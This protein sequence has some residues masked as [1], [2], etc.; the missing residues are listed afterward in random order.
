MFI[1]S[2]GDG[3][4]AVIPNLIARVC[5][6][7][8]HSILTVSVIKSAIYSMAATRQR[9]L[10]MKSM[11]LCSPW[12]ATGIAIRS[13]RIWFGSSMSIPTAVIAITWRVV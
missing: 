9:W 8:T 11:I 2:V 6:D 1:S 12:F 10:V 7:P 13:E 4:A 5:S 3:I